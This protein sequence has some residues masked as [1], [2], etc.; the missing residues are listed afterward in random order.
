MINISL[1]LLTLH[2]IA[3]FVLQSDWMAIN[4]SKNWGAL[5]LLAYTAKL[6]GV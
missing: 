1:I 2:F 6:I 5:A 3:D 4:K